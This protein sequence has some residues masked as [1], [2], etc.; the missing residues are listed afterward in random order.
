[1]EHSISLS[2]MDG[3]LV[4]EYCSS[5]E[6]ENF[7]DLAPALEFILK[8]GQKRLEDLRAIFVAI[9]PGK[10]TGLRVGVSFAKG[11]SYAL[12]IPLLGINSLDAMANS[13]PFLGEAL[14]VFIE[15][16]RDE[17]FVGLYRKEGE[18]LVSDGPI[19][20]LGKG[21]LKEIRRDGLYVLGHNYNKLWP[22]LRDQLGEGVIALPPWHWNLKGCGLLALGLERLERGERDDPTLLEPLYLRGPEIRP[23]S[24]GILWDLGK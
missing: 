21:E 8:A 9:G 18:L 2:R 5:S 3:S 22:I 23:V 13:I 6:K 16:R 20:V 14:A 4:A 15:S 11:L 24:G 12:N 7:R 1:P 10:F 17:W 19:M